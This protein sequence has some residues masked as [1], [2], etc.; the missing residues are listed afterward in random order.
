MAG[1]GLEVVDRALDLDDGGDMWLPFR[2]RDGGFCVEH[3]NGA[4]FVAV[5]PFLV[6]GLD[7]RQRLGCGADGFGL[8]TKDRLVVLEL[9][10]Q[11][12]VGEGGGFE[13][14]FWQC[15]ASQ[16]TRCPATSSSC[17][18]FCTAGIS[19]DFSSISI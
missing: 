17:N 13:S 6:H 18:S 11:M 9:D 8:L 15:M 2:P 16:V 12:R 3:C 7:A 14:F 5:S 10:D 19:L 1:G 4:S